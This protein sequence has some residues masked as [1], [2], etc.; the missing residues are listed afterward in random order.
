MIR[1]FILFRRLFFFLKRLFRHKFLLILALFFVL[2]GRGEAV[3]DAVDFNKVVDDVP[4]IE[5]QSLSSVASSYLDCDYKRFC[6]AYGYDNVPWCA[7]FV[8]YCAEEA[9]LSVVPSA[10]CNE[11]FDNNNGISDVTDFRVNDVLF[12]DYNSDAVLDHVGIVSAVNGDM[13]TTIEGNVDD[14]VSYGSYSADDPSLYGVVR[15]SGGVSVATL[16]RDFN[17][18]DNVGT[19]NVSL[20]SGLTGKVSPVDDYVYA[21]TGDYQYVFAWGDLDLSGSLFSGPCDY[22]VYERV[23]SSYNSQYTYTVFHDDNFQLNAG[24]YIVYSSL[25]KY[26][27]IGGNDNVRWLAPLTVFVALCVGLLIFVIPFCWCCGRYRQHL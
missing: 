19:S 4:V 13:L 14:C 27:L 26:P 24:N 18:S 22:V 21:R 15:L 25:G 2:A 9:G 6:D 12:F 17:V 8:S 5:T 16:A 23:N 7:L 20:F 11:L 10:N 1:D 3:Y